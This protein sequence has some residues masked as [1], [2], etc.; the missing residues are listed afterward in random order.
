MVFQDTRFEVAVLI[1]TRATA[2]HQPEFSLLEILVT[3]SPSVWTT[4]GSQWLAQLAAMRQSI[5]Y[6][7]LDEQY[8]RNQGYGKNL[9][10][11]DEDLIG[12]QIAIWA[13]FS[14]FE[15]N[16]DSYGTGSQVPIRHQNERQQVSY[17]IEWLRN[18][19][20]AFTTRK[21]GLNA[22]PLQTRLCALLASDQN[23]TIP[24]TEHDF[25]KH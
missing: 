18:Q 11:E 24:M 10:V 7:K 13:L 15:E 19:C 4:D 16:E 21:I 1:F 12:Q 3:M 22:R 14:P 20:I 6:L 25:I 2:R 17:D 8:G 5:S 9:K 23:G